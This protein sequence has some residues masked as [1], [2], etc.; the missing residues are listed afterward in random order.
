MAEL[1]VMESLFDYLLGFFK[2]IVRRARKAHLLS[3]LQYQML[4][5]LKKLFI[6][7]CFVLALTSLNR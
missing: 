1:P 7:Q 2:N 4:M 6:V 3:T 5:F